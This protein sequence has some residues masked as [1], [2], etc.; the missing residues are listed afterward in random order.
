MLGRLPHEFDNRN[1]NEE[2][3]IFRCK[4]SKFTVYLRL[5]KQTVRI[6]ASKCVYFLFAISISLIECTAHAKGPYIGDCMWKGGS[7]ES[8]TFICF[9]E[10]V[11]DR[12][13]NYVHSRKPCIN[14]KDG[15]IKDEI[16]QISFQN[17]QFAK[18]P[19][20]IIEFYRF[21]W[22]LDISDV[23]LKFLTKT[24]FCGRHKQRLR[25]LNASH[26][27]LTE[28][29]PGLFD[30]M[31]HI[32]DVDFS[33]NKIKHIE[34]A[35][36]TNA[37]EMLSLNL[38]NNHLADIPNRT[39]QFLQSLK[40]LSLSNN[41]I[42]HVDAL[43]FRGLRALV[44]LDLSGNKFTKLNPDAFEELPV[45]S[46][47]VSHNQ[48]TKITAKLFEHI[49]QLQI[50]DISYNNIT[51]LNGLL[52]GNNITGLTEL[53]VS[54]NHIKS[55]SKL[56]SAN[57][58]QLIRLDVSKNEIS[59]LDGNIFYNFIKLVVINLSCNP[60][61]KLNPLTFAKH[62][63]ILYLNLSQTNLLSIESKTFSKLQK[64]QTLDLSKNQLKKIDFKIFLP[65]LKELQ[66]FCLEGNKLTELTGFKK[67][68]FP[69]LQTLGIQN[70]NFNCSYVHTFFDS[71]VWPELNIDSERL[72]SFAVE[73][74]N[75][76]GI[77]CRMV[78]DFDYEEINDNGEV[79]I[80]RLHNKKIN[81]KPE[82]YIAKPS[83]NTLFPQWLVTLF[84]L[85]VF[86]ALIASVVVYRNDIMKLLPTNKISYRRNFHNSSLTINAEP[87]HFSE[88]IRKEESD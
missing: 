38:S 15:Y 79:A 42:E 36:F 39:F 77:R 55:I 82:N 20:D 28:I 78:E 47:N 7:P 24:N 31:Q 37:S 70:N 68:L 67:Q 34:T 4:A 46:L 13:F 18:I 44:E 6:M 88:R 49:R 76:G 48:L 52:V 27:L 80:I 9:Q 84:C 10:S 54:N 71:M 85:V 25:A 66:M 72:Y 41:K 11:P 23:S 57:F 16:G 40:I 74:D 12:F 45:I 64:L 69:K 75:V 32:Q 50:L 35:C 29:E 61:K 87:M 21:I 62:A 17:C 60:I 51:D 14:N 30:G 58:T 22:K 73:E 8:L 2:I 65:S 26:N 63:N 3:F 1:L 43:T 86:V 56:A 5:A 81:R 19:V 59:Q 33:F 83:T 53:Y